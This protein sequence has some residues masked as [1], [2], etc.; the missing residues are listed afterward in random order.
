MKTVLQA[1][2]NAGIICLFFTII[3]LTQCANIFAELDMAAYCTDQRSLCQKTGSFIH[4]V[5]EYYGKIGSSCS[6]F[7]E[8]PLDDS[9]EGAILKGINRIRAKTAL[10][11]ITG[12]GLEPLPRAY[13]V[14]KIFWDSEL[15]A[16]A[17]IM[18]NQCITRPRY[19]CAASK[20]FASPMMVYA[21]TNTTSSATAIIDNV[22]SS[23]EADAWTT[24]PDEI[25]HA[26]D[27]K[28][29]P[30]PFIDLV[31]GDVTHMGCAAAT[32]EHEIRP[33]AITA[34]DN[35][36]LS[37]H[38]VCYLSHYS[39]EGTP[40]YNT[41]E[42]IPGTWWTKCGCPPMY[43]ETRECLCVPF[44]PL[45]HAPKLPVL[46]QNSANT[47]T[48]STPVYYENLDKYMQFVY[49]ID[50]A[51]SKPAE[52]SQL[53]NL[54]T[55][56]RLELTPQQNLEWTPKET[57]NIEMRQR[58]VPAIE[59]TL[60]GTKAVPISRIGDRTSTAT[61]SSAVRCEPKIVMLPI[62]TIQNAPK[63]HNR[64]RRRGF[65]RR[66]ANTSLV[67]NAEDDISFSDENYE[68]LPQ[69][70]S[71]RP[72]VLEKVNKIRQKQA[73]D[74]FSNEN[75][76]HGEIRKAKAVSTTTTK[77]S[78][79]PTT[80][81]PQNDAKNSVLNVLEI[82]EEQEK[83][84]ESHSD[85]TEPSQPIINRRSTDNP[86]EIAKKKVMHLLDLLEQKGGKAR[87]NS[88]EMVE[89]DTKMKRIYT[90]VL[91]TTRK[92]DFIKLWNF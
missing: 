86:K 37:G 40:V 41:T 27:L 34:N 16:F 53:L 92:G 18:I 82:L 58:I 48:T 68:E 11:T 66:S 3:N 8:V 90:S 22:L 33:I 29:E 20:N 88:R 63:P 60:M 7:N 61:C 71:I 65:F 45:E 38:I 78:R 14:K 21:F 67:P 84:L 25:L 79:Q 42:P 57:L 12:K 24:T 26:P 44:P 35:I 83:A 75:A 17:K 30:R 10:G 69:N 9:N 81:K 91:G 77:E 54:T 52:K 62:F 73:R 49:N 89:F 36:R 32:Y 2:I 13:G 5:C 15:A 23:W 39:R 51:Q 76:K 70:K 43:R 55:E 87:L 85:V 1:L 50:S 4:I 47:T 72:K 59:Q 64:R 31:V 19:S 80:N 74:I 46:R 56:K 6:M 28:G